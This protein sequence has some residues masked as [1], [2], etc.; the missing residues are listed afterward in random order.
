MTLLGPLALPGIYLAQSVASHLPRRALARLQ[1]RRLRR[2]L[3]IATA[4]SPFYRSRFAG[5]APDPMRLE[6]LPTTTRHAVM[7]HFDEVVT[8]PRLRLAELRAWL[9]DPGNAGRLYL[10]RYSA[11]HTSGTTGEP[12]V[13]VYD[14]RA[15]HWIHGAFLAR[16]AASQSARLRS[17]AGAALGRSLRLASVVLTEGAFPAAGAVRYQSWLHR[18]LVDHRVISSEQT[19]PDIVRELNAFQPDLL[20][21]YAGV[22]ELLA[23]R[24]VEG[25]LRLRFRH[26]LAAVVSMSEVLTE[27]AKEL[28]L[29]AWG[30][31]VQDTYAAAE[32]LAMGRSCRH[33]RLHL[34]TDMC[35]LEPVD[36]D[37]RP[38]PAGEPGERV[39][40]TNLF[41][42]A[43]PLIRYEL[44]D[45]TGL[46]AEPCA[47][48]SPFPVLLPIEGRSGDV[49]W[50]Q[51]QDG[52]RRKVSPGYLLRELYALECLRDYQVRQTGVDEL[53]CYFATGRED[54][55]AVREQ[56]A[57]AVRAGVRAAGLQRAPRL[58][59]EAVATIP[60]HPVSGKRQLVVGMNSLAGP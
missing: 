30:M 12:I 36:A 50:L 29:Q 48:G 39:L 58:R 57:R 53:T 14:R 40:L 17:L 2:L 42:T 34:F 20:L 21:T 37:N 5:L 54:G 47:C 41:N 1:Q 49:L 24:Q 4:R 33:G 18:W 27:R 16:H 22:V 25:E 11:M 7:E 60:R 51:E 52:T 32:C 6:A 45:V 31:P 9:D 10:G 8:D 55:D 13:V 23:E 15:M 35:V 59:L 43:Q 19:L 46:A 3:A 44:S 56:V 28:A 26:P 38:V